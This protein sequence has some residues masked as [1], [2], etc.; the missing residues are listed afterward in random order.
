MAKG[1]KKKKSTLIKLNAIDVFPNTEE[2]EE[3]AGG[4]QKGSAP[5]KEQPPKHRS[6][7]EERYHARKIPKVDDGI[8]FNDFS[9][10]GLKQYYANNHISEFVKPEG[11][12]KYIKFEFT[13]MLDGYRANLDENGENP[14]IRKLCYAELT[15]TSFINNI[16]LTARYINYFIEYF[17]DD[18]ELMHAYFQLMFQISSRNNQMDVSS[19]IENILA[20]IATEDMIDKVVRMV[21]YN[22]DESLIKKTDRIYDESIQLTVEHLKA[23]M[24]ISCFHKF[25]IPIVS[26]YYSLHRKD[27][28]K[29]GWDSKTLYYSVFAS[30]IT[31]FDEHYDIRLYE[32]LYHTATTRIS[33]TENRE[34]AMWNRRNRFGITP[35]SFTNQLM[36]DYLLDISQKAVFSHSAIVFLHVCFDNSIRNELITPDRYEMSD[37]KMEA[38]DSVNETISRFDRWQ[39]DKTFH[40]ERDRLRAYVSIQES[41]DRLGYEVGMDFPRM[42][43]KDFKDIRA[44]TELREEYEYYL[45][46]I[47]NPLHDTQMYIIQLYYSNRLA[48]SEDVKMMEVPDIIKLIMIMKR[49]F[50]ARN[51]NYLQFFISSKVNTTANRRLNKRKIEKMFLSHP[52][53]EDWLEEFPDTQP[54]INM[55]RL[56]GEIKTI[57]SCPINVVDYAYVEHRGHMMTPNDIC[58][59][60]E[61]VRFLCEI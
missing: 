58:A 47:P 17:D 18:D 13:S 29:E 26:H 43:S 19:F 49:D 9:Y 6:I 10:D 38:S 51:Y 4:K 15:K 3:T 20:Q 41:L 28:E 57:I 34:S 32:K 53:Y 42:R 22:T 33:K 55:D 54:L 7:L 27:L 59:L 37:M 61:V 39:M 36:R 8:R 5:V 14:V 60:D 40:S 1:R 50:A 21:E 46:N 11:Q 12:G 35:T 24:G 44:T 45:E 25:V 23:I 56:L 48:S 30:F 16:N 2:Q 31:L 52:S